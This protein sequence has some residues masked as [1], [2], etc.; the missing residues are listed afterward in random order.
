M[1]LTNRVFYS[2]QFQF[3]VVHS[4]HFML[5]I[6]PLIP[7]QSVRLHNPADVQVLARD[8]LN[9]TCVIH[10][11]GVIFVAEKDSLSYLEVGNIVKLNPKALKKPRL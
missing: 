3:A 10:E 5:W 2:I 8:I 4:V 7:F 9:P 6:T 1:A 11:S